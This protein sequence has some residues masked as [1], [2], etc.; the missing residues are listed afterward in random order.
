[1]SGFPHRTPSLRSVLSR[2]DTLSPAS[3]F[4][5]PQLAA[6][7]D[8]TPLPSPLMPE[9]P[10]W[11]LD[12]QEGMKAN[13]MSIRPSTADATTQSSSN[14]TLSP[15]QYSPRK[16][17]AYLGLQ[18]PQAVSQS[19]KETNEANH[20][21]NRSLSEYVPNHMQMPKNRTVTVSQT[22]TMPSMGP[23]GSMHREQYLAIERGV[24][25][26]L[27]TPPRSDKSGEVEDD[28]PPTLHVPPA[29][30]PN[31]E[32]YTARTVADDQPR[33][34]R[35]I[36]EL[37][38]GTF[39]KVM[40]AE[41]VD[42]SRQGPGRLVAVKVIEHGPAGGA[43]EERIEVSLKRELEILRAIKHPSLVHLKAFNIM[44]KRS[45]L[46][47]NYCPGSD[48]FAVASECHSLLVPTLIRRIFA[49]LVAAVQYLH[50]Q[51]IVHR[52]IKLESMSILLHIIRH[53]CY[54]LL[55]DIAGRRAPE[56]CSGRSSQRE[57]LDDLQPASG[58][59]ERH[60]PVSL[61]RPGIPN[62]PNSMW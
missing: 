21:R 25:T 8:I 29:D 24:A 44:E 22:P 17:R 15:T 26:Q 54:V 39:S 5:S 36:E 11:K 47:L 43:D 56:C 46:V 9:L 32:S 10:I 60:G 28:G 6:M 55:A 2:V 45:Y 4:T 35:A 20:E 58:L 51:L 13:D 57:R 33:T 38:V 41:D 53:Q 62:A 7:A 59:L 16:R 30:D 52:D 23:D 18:P 40:L 34:Y 48:L 19:I 37:G 12:T 31:V 42:V 61:Y 3:S 50:S 14:M 27:P 1:M 49:E